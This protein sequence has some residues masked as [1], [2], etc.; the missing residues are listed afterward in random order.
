MGGHSAPA[1]R[2][3]VVM[4]HGWYGFGLDPDAAAKCL[5]G[6]ARAAADHDRPAELGQLEISVTP[7]ARPTPET[8]E[9]YA[10]LG[11]DRLVWLPNGETV[12]DWL[13]FVDRVGSE[14][15]A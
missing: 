6:L 5:D 8:V 2:R 4:S 11:V 10:E 13:A 9:Q 14:L 12:D 1:F 3:A 15:I 7:R